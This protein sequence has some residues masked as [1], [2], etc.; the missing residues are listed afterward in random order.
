MNIRN[1]LITLCLLAVFPL[2]VSA[3]VLTVLPGKSIQEKIDEAEDNDFVA[4][5]GGTYNENLTIDNKVI[6][7]VEVKGQ[8]VTISGNVTF[9]NCS[10]VPPLEGFEFKGGKA[11][12]FLNCEGEILLRNINHEEGERIE[13]SSENGRLVIDSSQIKRLNVDRGSAEISNSDVKIEVNQTSGSLTAVKSNIGKINTQSATP[14]TVLYRCT[15]GGGEADR[16]WESFYRSKRLWMGYSTVYNGASWF[17]EVD[18]GSKHVVV[19]CEFD[20]ESQKGGDSRERTLV[21]IEKFNSS[22]FSIINSKIHNVYQYNWNAWHDHCIEARSCDN[23]NF[24]VQ[25]NYLQTNHHGGGD[26]RGTMWL[27]IGESN[28]VIIRNNVS[29]AYTYLGHFP[30]GALIEG[31][32]SFTSWLDPIAVTGGAVIGTGNIAYDV[33]ISATRNPEQGKLVAVA[34]D[35]FKNDNV[36]ELSEGS[37]L[38]DAGVDNALF[39]DRDGSRNDAGPS[40]GVWFDPDGWT[41]DKPVV[42][43]FEVSSDLVLEGVDTEVILSEGQAVTAP[44]SSE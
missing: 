7:L 12:A 37:S 5:F 15:I 16:N 21:R 4:I 23:S 1:I 39:N 19:G 44:A 9:Q 41:T 3:K 25:N 29:I 24:L 14:K 33:E 38:K 43:S 40:G 10:T 42:I 13:F 20:Q 26:P 30:F 28:K 31:N 6:R 11:L 8:D 32:H 27:D 35:L 18:A 36:Y 17:R 34:Q 22:S 2:T